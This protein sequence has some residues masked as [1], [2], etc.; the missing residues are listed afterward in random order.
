M[1]F[2]AAEKNGSPPKI[3]VV[4]SAQ[5]TIEP[6]P[7][8]GFIDAIPFAFERQ[9]LSFVFEELPA[10]TLLAFMGAAIG[11]IM[12]VDVMAADAKSAAHMK[13][14]LAGLDTDYGSRLPE[15][16]IDHGLPRIGSAPDL[17][18]VTGMSDTRVSFHAAE[19]KSRIA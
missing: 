11:V 7:C 13:C 9:W 14:S 12:S 8:A 1:L 18:S 19:S 4:A 5:S 15:V 2:A 16:L 3:S 17:A 10:L 6:G